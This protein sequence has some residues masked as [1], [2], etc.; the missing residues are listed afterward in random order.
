MVSVSRLLMLEA[1]ARV[2]SIAP[3][4]V[5]GVLIAQLT[6]ID[7]QLPNLLNRT[8]NAMDLAVYQGF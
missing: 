7:V 6:H 1:R 3:C 2:P 8:L 4:G 5:V